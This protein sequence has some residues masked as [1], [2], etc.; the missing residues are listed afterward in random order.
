M[1]GQDD[2]LIHMQTNRQ[3]PTQGDAGKLQTERPDCTHKT[4][5]ENGRAAWCMGWTHCLE[6]PLPGPDDLVE[7]VTNSRTWDEDLSVVTMH[8]RGRSTTLNCLGGPHDP[9][10]GPPKTLQHTSLK[11]R[12]YTWSC[13][14]CKRGHSDPIWRSHPGFLFQE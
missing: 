14:A 2:Q 11:P 1:E 6:W 10:R 12:G 9:S 8:A 13:L 7:A 3:G 4:W 5:T